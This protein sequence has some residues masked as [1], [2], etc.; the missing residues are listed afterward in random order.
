MSNRRIN[1]LAS[2]MVVFLAGF[3]SLAIPVDDQAIRSISS[4]VP[5]DPDDNNQSTAA[6]DDA[7][8]AS[9]EI[10]LLHGTLNWPSSGV[11]RPRW[12][13]NSRCILALDLPTS[14]TLES[15]HVL[16]RL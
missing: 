16:L 12:Q 15:Q 9:D 5:C 2:V 7:N 11:P 10:L 1:V 14:A 8:D 4:Q 13:W 3:Y 6:I